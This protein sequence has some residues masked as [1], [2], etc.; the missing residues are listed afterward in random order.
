MSD[1]IVRTA[2]MENLQKLAEMSSSLNQSGN[3][4]DCRPGFISAVELAIDRG[5]E[6]FISPTFVL[7]APF[8][9][10]TKT[11][12]ALQA[13]EHG[14]PLHLTWSCLTGDTEVIT[15]NGNRTIA[16]LK[17]GEWVWGYD[18]ERGWIPALVEN[19]FVQGVKPVYEVVLDDGMGQLSMFRATGDHLLMLRD[20]SY[21]R[22]DSLQRG[23]RLMPATVSTLTVGKT[24]K[25][26]FAVRRNNL[27]TE[28]MTYMH[29]IVAEFFGQDI[30]GNVVHHQNDNTF[31]NRPEN[32]V[33][34]PRGDHS[35]L[36]DRTMLSGSEESSRLKRDAAFKQHGTEG[37]ERYL[38]AEQLFNEGWSKTAIAKELG[39]G[40]IAGV[41]NAINRA[42]EMENHKIVSIVPAGE[43]MTFDIQ[44]ST[45]N[46][47]IG[48][49]IFV[50][51]CYKGG[52]NHCGRCGTCVERLEAID[53]AKT[54]YLQGKEYTPMD[55]WMLD[56]TVYDDNEFWRHA[57]RG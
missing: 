13:F 41:T 56:Q 22:L 12:I 40:S 7:E 31:D 8:L 23:A 47:A 57:T 54:L 18:N 44:T 38:R 33:A 50:H 21:A 51:N 46:F 6:G 45:R 52:E 36:T 4:K 24:K 49:G 39:Y 37:V 35:R 28:Q 17:P 27:W 26:Y 3:R 25:R 53:E 15:L 10:S 20:G 48:A 16:S 34:M 19:F 55:E 29:R 42:R 11:D 30:D 32:L 5:N 43:E 2:G 14:V 9:H 1:A